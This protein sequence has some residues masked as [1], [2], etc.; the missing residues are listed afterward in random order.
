MIS[1]LTMLTRLAGTDKSKAGRS[2]IRLYRMESGR[3]GIFGAEPALLPIRSRG[4]SRPVRPPCIDNRA[5]I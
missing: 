5:A 1:I 4:I 3:L 2:F